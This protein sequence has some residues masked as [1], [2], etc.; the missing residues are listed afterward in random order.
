MRTKIIVISLVLLVGIQTAQATIYV[1]ESGWLANGEFKLNSTPLTSAIDNAAQGE[2]IILRDGTYT[3]SVMVDKRMSIRSQNG[4]HKCIID[5]YSTKNVLEIN[6]DGVNITGL[7][8]TGARYDQAGVRVGANYS[9]VTNCNIWD[10]DRGIYVRGTSSDLAQY[11]YVGNNSIYDCEVG[12]KLSGKGVKDGE[13]M[14]N[15]IYNTGQGIKLI[16]S[17]DNHIKYNDIHSSE[18]GVYLQNADR[19]N[20]TNNYVHRNG[21]GIY[22]SDTGGSSVDNV[23]TNNNIVD[24]NGYQLYND[25]DVE[26]DAPMNFWGNFTNAS[27]DELIFDDE[28]GKGQVSFYPFLSNTA[29]VPE[30]PTIILA[31]AGLILVGRGFNGRD[32]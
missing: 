6:V 2:E 31:L 25:Q 9:S 7:N 30:L 11:S 24:N 27:I 19:N 14:A 1:N 21:I 4:S 10:C 20:V 16:D 17:D 29:P 32:K 13:F 5:G 22:L 28:E 15:T 8:I 3:E 26:V 12:I 18:Y 23:I